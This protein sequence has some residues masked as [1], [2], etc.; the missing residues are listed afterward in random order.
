[1]QRSPHVVAVCGSLSD[2]SGTRTALKTA[3]DAASDAGA[4]TDLV[5]LRNYDLPPR[6]GDNRDAGDAPELRERVAAADA[7]LLGTPMYHG[8]YSAPLKNA[9]DYCGR[10]E[11]GGKAV[12]LL[13]VA[14]GS[15]P[16]QALG[17]LR[18][19]C[20]ALDAWALPL[21]VAVPSS[22]STFADGAFADD[23]LEER[24]RRLG[25][26]AVAYAGVEQYPDL[27]AAAGDDRPVAATQD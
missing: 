16:R 22:G 19:V 25:E 10:D 21:Q 4:T 17:H 15:F 18:T 6:D 23:D 24:T 20:R 14:G 7:V 26:Q 11:L 5:D 13:S 27:A 2:D 9:L 8:S 12:G 1:M 3:L